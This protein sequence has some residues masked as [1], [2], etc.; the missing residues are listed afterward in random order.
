MSH[1]AKS[2]RRL[3]LCMPPTGFAVLVIATSMVSTP[4]P[5]MSVTMSA[6]QLLGSKSEPEWI[7]LAASRSRSRTPP[8]S[9][10]AVPP[11][12]SGPGGQFVGRAPPRYVPSSKQPVDPRL[13]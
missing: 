7:T 12:V 3:S 9:Q 11:P 5:A 4:V 13:N 8:S 10:A 1:T 2:I 6:N